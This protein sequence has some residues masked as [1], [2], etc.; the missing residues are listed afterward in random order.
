MIE[1]YGIRSA[2]TYHEG[3]TKANPT[4]SGI[5]CN[6]IRMRLLLWNAKEQILITDG[7]VKTLTLTE[8]KWSLADQGSKRYLNKKTK[9]SN[10]FLIQGGHTH[11]QVEN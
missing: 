10:Y 4:I 3:K 11:G 7:S 8:S 9:V 1:K 2:S 6:L 5:Q